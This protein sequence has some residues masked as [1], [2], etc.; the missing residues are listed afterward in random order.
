MLTGWK[1]LVYE[2]VLAYC[3]HEGFR[4]FTLTALL[5]YALPALAEAYPN[6]QHPEAK[7]RQTLQYLRDEGLLAFTDQRGTYTL[8][9]VPLLANE[10]DDSFVTHLQAQPPERR[11]YLIETFARKRGWVRQALAH[12]GPYCLL[13][14]DGHVCGNTFLR[15]DGEPYIEVHHII[16]L[17]HGGEEGLWNLA[18]LC[19]HHHR[20]AHYANLATRLTL[21]RDLL[22]AVALR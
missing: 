4:T 21:Q 5:R 20:M 15:D 18:P 12:Y 6:N 10:V 8:A 1:R 16:P 7:L 17:A 11:E 13:K 14:P 3:H 19:A 22:A 9:G 2:Q